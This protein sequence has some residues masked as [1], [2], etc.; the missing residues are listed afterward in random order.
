MSSAVIDLT[1]ETV[2]LEIDDLE[3][4]SRQSHTDSDAAIAIEFSEEINSYEM[5][6]LGFE[7]QPV[8][9]VTPVPSPA[10]PA[11]VMQNPITQPRPRAHIRPKCPRVRSFQQDT[12][13]KQEC[14]I[15]YEKLSRK[16]STKLKC[17]HVYH[18]KCI[19]KWSKQAM[20][21]PMDRK[22]IRASELK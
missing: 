17:G 16:R 19:R 4:N 20:V 18:T 10:Q 7:F 1:F 8:Q 21:C 12:D 5:D 3:I 11:R 9:L 22:K 15:C 6:F 2:D 13:P 14:C